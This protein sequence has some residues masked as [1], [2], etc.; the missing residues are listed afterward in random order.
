VT[1]LTE[2]PITFTTFLFVSL[3]YSV[4]AV[5]VFV[6]IFFLIVTSLFELFPGFLI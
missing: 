4:L 6:V 2:V 3:F 5:V 1:S